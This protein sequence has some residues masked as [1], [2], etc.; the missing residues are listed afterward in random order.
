MLTLY[1]LLGVF[2]VLVVAG[3]HQIEQVLIRIEEELKR[4]NEALRKES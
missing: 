4:I 1:V 3:I 2:A